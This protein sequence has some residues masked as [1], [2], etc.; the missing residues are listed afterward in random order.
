M[1]CL[2]IYC[3]VALSALLHMGKVPSRRLLAGALLLNLLDVAGETF[4]WYGNLPMSRFLLGLV[5]GIGTGAVLLSRQLP[6]PE[7]PF[8]PR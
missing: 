8:Q 4:H 3:G 1:R 5:L 7:I 2:G 6:K